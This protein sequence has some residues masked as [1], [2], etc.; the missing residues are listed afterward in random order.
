M[1]K[2]QDTKYD[3]RAPPRRRA[4]G[5][6]FD[7][8][9]VFL[10]K[11]F[12]VFT[13]CPSEI[14]GW[15]EKGDT[16]L[17]KDVKQFSE[18]VIPTAYKHNN[19][20]SFVRQLNFYGFRKVKSESM[21]HADWWEFR[22]PQFLRDEPHLISEIKRSVHFEAGSG[23]EVSELKTQVT[24][25]NDRITALNDQIDKLTGLVTNMQIKEDSNKAMIN[26]DKSATHEMDG[27]KRRKLSVKNLAA[28]RVSLS[29]GAPIPLQRQ[30]SLDSSMMI[31]EFEA[32]GEELP[33]GPDLMMLT[34]NSD[35]FALNNKNQEDEALL[36]EQ[37][38]SDDMD[39]LF[40]ENDAADLPQDNKYIKTEI[41]H[42]SSVPAMA[43]TAPTP[44]VA[45]IGAVSAAASDISS[46]LD[47]L[48]PELRLRFVDRLAEV[49]GAQLTQNISQQVQVNVQV[50]QQAQQQQQQQPVQQML[51]QQPYLYVAAPASSA[52]AAPAVA[53]TN[54]ISADP[55]HFLLPSGS[56]APEIALPLASAAIA[57]LLS[58]MQSFA[59]N[60]QMQMH[61]QQ[62]NS[63]SV[64]IKEEVACK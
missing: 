48:S 15:S 24:G 28:H 43:A 1:S 38:W 14:G 33:S 4:K 51:V 9:P 8:Q 58:S 11:A 37:S 60:T 49:M 3:T 40:S 5:D 29:P 25:L 45:A 56:R 18:K 10:R 61:L 6:E 2:T 12:A 55:A 42:A 21:D 53:Q 17:I 54:I 32:A 64:P 50:A 52:Q 35:F 63:T 47:S 46:V 22:H 23:Q 31:G 36:L 57:A 44:T 59:Q 41:P 62:S 34:E 19:F 27:Q 30:H 26:S 13:T 20:T 39:I 7:D 16:V